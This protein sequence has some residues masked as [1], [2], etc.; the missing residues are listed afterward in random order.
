M[1]DITIPSHNRLYLTRPDPAIEMGYRSISAMREMLS[2]EAVFAALKQAI[3]EFHRAAPEDHDILI[4]SHDIFV[5]EVG[6]IYPHSFVFKG[7]DGDGHRAIVVVHHSQLVAR[8][9]SIAKRGPT[10]VI[11]GF[12]PHHED[13]EEN[14]E[15]EQD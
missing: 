15:A 2:G 13:A 7:S 12:C 5:T 10:R 6:F 14:E 11:T 4:V 8:V 3:E 9:V 1:E